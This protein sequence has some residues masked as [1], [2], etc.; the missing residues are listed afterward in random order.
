MPPKGFSLFVVS[1]LKP[2]GILSLCRSSNAA[3]SYSWWKSRTAPTKSVPRW[4]RGWMGKDGALDPRWVQGQVQGHLKSPR[5]LNLVWEQA[6]TDYQFTWP[7]L[8]D[9]PIPLATDLRIFNGLVL[10]WQNKIREAKEE[11]GQREKWKK[12]TRVWAEKYSYQERL[13][14]SRKLWNAH[15]LEYYV[16]IIN[17]VCHETG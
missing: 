12:Q 4:W 6:L 13:S 17:Q 5:E 1:A 2:L 7:V 10:I 11:P 9:F 8:P 16:A 15:R 14:V 3:T